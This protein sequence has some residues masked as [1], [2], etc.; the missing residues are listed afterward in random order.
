MSG[1]SEHIVREYFEV[2]GFSVRPLRKYAV[3]NR[4]RNAED[5]IDLVVDNQS[6]E[7]GEAISNFQLFSGDVL[8]LERAVV[9]LVSWHSS[10]FT[11]S[12]LQSSRKVFE[13]LKKDV[14]NKMH[15]F[16]NMD[17]DGIDGAVAKNSQSF[18]K[19]LI[20][21][22]LPTSEP[23]RS[24]S[25]AMLK[26]HGVDGIIAYSTILENLLRYVEVNHS[27][28]NSQLLQ[29]LRILKLY[30]MLKTPQMSLFN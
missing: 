6:V 12:I 4:K 14:L 2:N 26:E 9:S 3:Q 25:I 30:D 11:P 21:P 1:F 23:Q 10:R 15:Q 22:G 16:L 8:R 13:F 20:L 19:L 7:A 24:E 29:M 27:Y 18:T 28:Q 17:A 5:S